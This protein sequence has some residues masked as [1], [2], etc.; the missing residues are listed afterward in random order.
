[1]R[2]SRYKG[3][4]ATSVPGYLF[5]RLTKMLLLLLLSLLLLSLLLSQR[6]TAEEQIQGAPSELEQPAE[7]CLCGHE[8]RRCERKL[9]AA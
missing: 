3:A 1:V 4:L 6:L 8:H 7:R 9:E 2:R 5:E